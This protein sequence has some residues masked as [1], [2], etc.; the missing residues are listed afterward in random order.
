MLSKETGFIPVDRKWENEIEINF[1]NEII[2]TVPIHSVKMLQTISL[3][4]FS[5]REIFIGVNLVWNA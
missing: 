1:G 5:L 3:R 2:T 4:S